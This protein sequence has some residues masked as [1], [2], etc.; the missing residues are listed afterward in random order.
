MTVQEYNVRI[1]PFYLR[2]EEEFLN[3]LNYVEFSKDNFKT[4]SIE[5]EKQILSIGSEVDILCKEVAP[6]SSPNQ[7]QEYREILYNYYENI[8][9][10]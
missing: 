7:I 2:L 9:I 3:S 5:Y 8:G 4:Y 1:W 6:D 10:E